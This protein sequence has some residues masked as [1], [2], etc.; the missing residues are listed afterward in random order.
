MSIRHPYIARVTTLLERMDQHEGLTL[1]DIQILHGLLVHICLI[2]ISGSSYLPAISNFMSQYNAN[3][4]IPCHASKS[5]HLTLT[6][7]NNQL[8]IQSF[9]HQLHSLQLL[10]DLGIF[11]DASMSWGIGIII[12]DKWYAFKLVP[13]W[14]VPGL[15]I[16]WLKAVALELLMYFLVQLGHCNAHLLMHSDNTGAIGAHDKACSRNIATNLCV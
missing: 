15:D 1:L 13:D 2:Y 8:S 6:W 5:L 10:D 7:W 3:N 4:F 12:G 9:H 11:L 16:G 14:K